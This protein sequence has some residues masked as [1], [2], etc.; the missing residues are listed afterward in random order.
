MI[1][2]KSQR[3]TWACCWTLKNFVTWVD[4]ATP[5]WREIKGLILDPPCS[6]RT[7]PLE[8]SDYTSVAS[9][10]N[11]IGDG[12]NESNLEVASTT[13]GLGD[14]GEGG[15]YARNEICEGP[16]VPFGCCTGEGTGECSGAGI[17]YRYENRVETRTPLFPWP[18]QDR[19]KAATTFAS[20]SNHT[21]LFAS[22]NPNNTPNCVQVEVNDPHA[23]ADVMADIEAM[24]GP[25]PAVC[26]GETGG[27]GG[28]TPPPPPDD[29]WRTD[30]EGEGQ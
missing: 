13:S 18:M 4:P 7:L 17:C 9:Q 27:D 8:L 6:A 10:P 3:P 26:K 29:V 23:V 24:F 30:T 2:W 21:H 28:L 25:V 1:G 16:D 11:A 12:W 14:A 15:I 19:I 5:E 22:C 20:A